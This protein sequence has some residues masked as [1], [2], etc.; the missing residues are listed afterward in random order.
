MVA[1]GAAAGRAP[2]AAQVPADQQVQQA[3]PTTLGFLE[4]LVNGLLPSTTL[5]PPPP[6]SPP[7]ATEAPPPDSAGEAPPADSGGESPPTTDVTQ[8]TI[9]PGAL[10]KINSVPRTGSRDTKGLLAALAP[11]TEVGLTLEEAA[12]LA[13]GSFPVA[14]D[15]H[16]SD[17]WWH[18]RF[19]PEFHLHMGTDI[20]APRGTPVRSPADGVVRF[21]G[22]AVGGLSAYVTADDGTSYYMTHLDSFSSEVRSGQRVSRGTV[23]AFVGNTG[24][25]EGGSHHVHFEVR[26]GGGPQVNPKPILDRW[27]E[28]AT[29]A[30][31]SFLTDFVGDEVN[32]SRALTS[33]GLLRRFDVGSFAG[34][35]S[36]S[37][38]P[39]LWA[40]S[41]RKAAG[42][43]LRLAE[44]AGSTQPADVGAATLVVSTAAGLH[45]SDQ[46]AQAAIGPLTPPVL[47]G[48]LGGASV[49]PS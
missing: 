40:A 5:P 29:A 28:E 8:R 20:F 2:V 33:A 46:V 49:R 14:G 32:V 36:A 16:Y 7:P 9:P 12:V 39:Q 34:P 21:A 1:G 44:F 3:P 37:A 26:P 10:A 48:L 45:R 38:G 13:F 30:V 35:T 27:L 18:P 31:G 42:E 47:D 17:D 43:N 22:E 24:N 15:A 23:V 11:L 41:I 4:G 6:S 25:A 19:T